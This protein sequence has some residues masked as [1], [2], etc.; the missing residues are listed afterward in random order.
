MN[1]LGYLDN[2]KFQLTDEEIEI[3]KVYFIKEGYPKKLFVNKR[4][5]ETLTLLKRW[6]VN[7]EKYNIIELAK[8]DSCTLDNLSNTK[9]VARILMLRICLEKNLNTFMFRT[10][11]YKCNIDVLQHLM[12]LMLF[13]NLD[14]TTILDYS[15]MDAREA[16]NFINAL[17]LG[18]EPREA[19]KYCRFLNYHLN[20][21]ITL[22]R[23]YKPDICICL[24]EQMKHHVNAKDLM[25]L[26]NRYKLNPY[27]SIEILNKLEDGDIQHWEYIVKKTNKSCIPNM[28]DWYGQY[29]KHL[30]GNSYTDNYFKNAVIETCYLANIPLFHID[31]IAKSDIPRIKQLIIKCLSKGIN[32]SI[33]L[34]LGLTYEE[35]NETLTILDKTEKYY[36][37]KPLALKLLNRM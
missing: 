37:V 13:K 34:N 27:D 18:V 16:I 20:E 11:A 1:L 28:T 21:Y 29:I 14:Y 23:K 26:I 33:Y 3:G 9:K 24:C 2:Y 4:I 10:Y 30:T 35:L 36:K 8:S 6:E 19:I 32:V 17:E 31:N 25:K 7:F 5:A 15:K 22:R 12:S